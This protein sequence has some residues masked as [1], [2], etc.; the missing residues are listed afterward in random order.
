MIKSEKK[1]ILRIIEKLT[2]NFS[3][4][5]LLSTGVVCLAV[6][7]LL[8]ISLFN[9]RYYQSL[10][11]SPIIGSQYT[12]SSNL[13]QRDYNIY[14]V[15]SLQEDVYI[16]ILIKD[17]AIENVYVDI[18]PNAEDFNVDRLRMHFYVKDQGN[19]MG[20]D[21]PA[22]D[23]TRGAWQTMYTYLDLSGKCNGFRLVIDEGLREGQ[24]IRIENLIFNMRVPFFFS[25]KRILVLTLLMVLIAILRPG[26]DISSVKAIDRFRGKKLLII[27]MFLA[28]VLLIHVICNLNGACRIQNSQTQHQFDMMAEAIIKGQPYL[29]ENPPEL[30]S[31]MDNPYSYQARIENGV[32]DE[33]LYDVAYYKGH[34][35][36]YFGVGPIIT[37]YVP[38]YLITGNHINTVDM[39]FFIGAL[40]IGGWMLLLYELV[41]RFFKDFSFTSYIICAFAFSAGC[42]L[43]YVISRPSFYA[44]PMTLGLACTLF[45][46]AFWLKALE[47]IEDGTVRI[48]PKFILVGSFFMAYVASCRPQFLVGSFLAIIIFWNATFRERSLFS[49]KSITATICFVLPYILI[50]AGLMYYNYIRFESVFD[51]GANYNLTFN[52]M[53]YRGFRLNRLLYAT[54]GFMFVPAKVSNKFPYFF[55]CDYVSTYQG[56]ITDEKL[57][58]GLFYNHLYLLSVIFIPKCKKYIKD[59]SA[60]LLALVAPILAIVVMIVDANMAGV[61]NRYFVDFSWLFFISF[62]IF[63][64][65]MITNE[66]LV[67]YRRIMEW[68][69]YVLAMISLIHMFF[70]IFGGDINGLENN[71]IMA[72]QRMK[73]YIEFWN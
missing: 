42:G 39:M 48:N 8:E 63:Y 43:T 49:K 64:G 33:C 22:L 7:I 55:P 59:N 15:S 70:L 67:Q 60:F 38:Y 14:E 32:Q 25:K 13:V 3:K 57:I 28:Q 61:L 1:Y 35:Y 23:Y 62:F 37:F 65:Y 26:S 45:G 10:A 44:I 11:Y 51:F 18:W 69:F 20:Y 68:A 52:D 71:N 29:E 46:L 58:G 31:K 34:Y 19:V 41:K 40:V 53:T 30:L 16:D 5:K 72:F 47:K 21:M 17:T 12:V 24:L 4:R 27:I 66:R 2:N 73:H 36:V 9:L 54:I 50:A 56:Y 6:A